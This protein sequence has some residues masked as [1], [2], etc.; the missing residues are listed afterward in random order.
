MILSQT[1]KIGCSA[2]GGGP[3]R[4]LLRLRLLLLLLLLLLLR[5]PWRRAEQ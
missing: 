5:I 1:L 3:S 4:R 2:K